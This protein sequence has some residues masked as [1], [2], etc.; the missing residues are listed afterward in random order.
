MN[1]WNKVIKSNFQK[2]WKVYSLIIILITPI[3][4][5]LVSSLY[6]IGGMGN[7]LNQIEGFRNKLILEASDFPTLSEIIYYLIC[8][9]TLFITGIFSWAILQ[10]S[11]KSNKL[12]EELKNKEDNK[13]NESVRESALI[14][15]YDLSL[16]IK[17]LNTLY[18]SRIIN[19]KNPMPRKIFFSNEWIKN[20]AVL[21]NNLSS[22]EINDI[23]SLYGNFLTIASLLDNVQTLDNYLITLDE[24][25]SKLVNEMYSS[26]FPKAF[27]KKYEDAPEKLLNRKYYLLFEKLR[28]LT[29]KKEQYKITKDNEVISTNIYLGD[30]QIYCGGN[31]GNNFNGYGKY[32]LPNGKIKFQGV[33]KDGHF[34]SG[35]VREFYSDD[36]IMYEVVYKDGIKVYG[37]L[38]Y[39]ED[40]KLFGGKL[41]YKGKFKDNIIVEGFSERYYYRNE[42]DVLYRGYLSN[43]K[44]E[45]RGVEYYDNYNRVEYDGIWKNGKIQTGKFFG[46]EET[47]KYF[48]G[49]F[50]NSEPFN[51]I[52][53]YGK[54]Y[55][56]DYVNEFKGEIKEGKLYN[57]KGK[58]MFLDWRGYTYADIDMLIIDENNEICYDDE[59]D[60]ECERQYKKESFAEV[61]K[62]YFD[63]EEYTDAEWQNGKFEVKEGDVLNKEIFYKKYSAKKH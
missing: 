36:N 34:M 27:L 9:Y 50:R 4:I 45:G 8:T 33:F 57:G 44:Y 12:A 10:S 43:G 51:G 55:V 6:I 30:K 25:I 7:I 56:T 62:K 38:F 59:Y 39:K 21:K 41:C 22:N 17:D 58:V 16:G 11:I 40:T 52:I 53:E 49:E 18:L 63:W 3:I 32:Y 48:V 37:K 15:Y 46:N 20:V 60:K 1:S 28:S 29:Y 35:T 2:N 24:E 61:K 5:T 23:Y 19:K 31:D 42:F 26:I 13:E 14:V 47:V 54:S